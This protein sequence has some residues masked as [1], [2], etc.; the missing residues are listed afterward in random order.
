MEPVAV[1]RLM[2]QILLFM[3]REFVCSNTGSPHHQLVSCLESGKEALLDFKSGL[4]DPE[5]WLFSW[6]G[7]NC[8][9]WEGISCD[10]RTGAVIEI[11]LHCSDQDPFS[12][13]G[14]KIRS[15]VT[16]LKS[17]RH[18]DL[19][20]CSFEGIPIPEFFGS[21]E[22][23]QYLNLAYTGFNG[24]I[25]PNLGNLS[26][27]RYLDLTS[28]GLVVRN[29]EWVVGLV[30]LKHLDM[31]GVDLSFVRLGWIRILSILPFLTELNM[32]FCSL[33][34][35]FPSHAFL[36][37]TSLA[38]LDLS[39]NNFNSR[40]PDSLVNVSS[41]VDVNMSFSG[42]YGSIPL[43]LADLPSLKFL[44]LDR[45]YNLTANCSQ[46]F[47]GKWEKIQIL[48]VD[49]N[50]LHGKL[51]ASIGNMKPLTVLSLSHNNVEGGIPSSICKLS[52][53]EFVD[54]SSNKLDGSLP[55]FLQGADNCLPSLQSLY[56]SK[57]QLVGKLPE[58][59][60][61]LKSV[62]VLD[63]SSNMLY[64][65]ILASLGSLSNLVELYLGMNR[66]NGTLPDSLGKLSNL[67]AFDV[68]SNQ[69]TGLVTEKYFQKLGKLM[70]LDFSSNSF[71]LNISS[72]WVPPFQ[73]MDLHMGSCHIDTSFPAWLKF[74]K[75]VNSLDFSNAGL[76]ASYHNGFGKFPAKCLT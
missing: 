74:Q 39:M 33:S 30:S 22:N 46:L 4:E 40:I 19:S 49:F 43:G 51:P 65:P 27:L 5:G 15:S 50:E 53:L 68:F 71:T 11:D 63:L 6:K 21:L 56:L 31:R 73:V 48:V 42:F 67:S 9:Q 12:E 16:K 24:T 60:G 62:E 7:N 66:L 18:L 26:S 59:L 34:G 58:W 72:N 41:L 61:Q 3:M 76:S 35:P 75:K 20:H 64:G 13:L 36:N 55:E 47:K 32:P 23:L 52:N 10:N 69:L 25:P 38:V 14:G 44:S 8:C 29:F 1:L 70:H 2:F 37:F 54:I 57:N 28:S 17:L 45:N